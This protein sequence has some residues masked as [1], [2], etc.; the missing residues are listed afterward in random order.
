ML[1]KDCQCGNRKT[2]EGTIVQGLK[3]DPCTFEI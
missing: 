2:N 3:I 1:F